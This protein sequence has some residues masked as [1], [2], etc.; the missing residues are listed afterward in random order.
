MAPLAAEIAVTEE[1]VSRAAMFDFLDNFGHRPAPVAVPKQES[2]GTEV[3]AERAAPRGNDSEGPEGTI[4]PQ[5][6]Q[7][8]TGQAQAGQVGQQLGPV[9][10]A[11]SSMQNILQHLGPDAFG[12]PDADRI[13]VCSR[14]FRVEEGV[15][16]AQDDRHAVD[17]KSTRLNSS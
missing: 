11:Q 4:A 5:V 6:Q 15:R 8:I 13:A 9:E 3:A 2:L 7:V 12:F 10:P 16:P 1:N 17:R 14:L